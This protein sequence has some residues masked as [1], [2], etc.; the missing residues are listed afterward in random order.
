V[1][2]G[3]PPLQK[4]NSSNDSSSLPTTPTTPS[5]PAAAAAIAQSL[6]NN[7][8]TTRAPP[9]DTVDSSV[10]YCICKRPYDVP[11]F[12]IACDKCDQ[13]F[14]GECIQISEKQGEFI[15][16]YFCEAC[17]KSKYSPLLF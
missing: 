1:K 5:T 14:H 10:L 11:R 17:A 16:L 7:T 13:W 4:V 6:L 12:M 15:D 3:R 2:R 8:T 9:T